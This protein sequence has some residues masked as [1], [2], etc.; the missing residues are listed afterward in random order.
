MCSSVKK[1]ALLLSVKLREEDEIK[2]FVGI[3][4]LTLAALFIWP[5]HTA[6][7]AVFLVGLAKECWN[8]QFGSGF[9]VFDMTSNV[10][11]SSAALLLGIVVVTSIGI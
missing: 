10:L 2:R 1:L 8:S 7:A 11:G 6:F 5:A 9:C 4:F 3:F